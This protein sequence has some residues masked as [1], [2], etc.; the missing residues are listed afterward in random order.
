MCNHVHLLAHTP[1]GNL[2]DVIRDLKKYTA[3]HI[4]DSLNGPEESRTYLADRFAFYARQAGKGKD[5]QFWT[6][7][8]HAEACFTE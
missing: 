1:D 5:R 7:E 4:L 8:N 3:R 6:H 2:S